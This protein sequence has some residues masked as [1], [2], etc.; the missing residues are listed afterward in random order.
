M[1]PQAVPL[2]AELEAAP[3]EQAGPVEPPRELMGQVRAVL[4][5]SAPV[6]CLRFSVQVWVRLSPQPAEVP[7]R[8]QGVR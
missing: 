6:L 4:R 7:V 5:L 1:Q 8:P 2:S 3:V